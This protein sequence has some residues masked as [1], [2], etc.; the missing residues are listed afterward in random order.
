MNRSFAAAVVTV[1]LAAIYM[2]IQVGMVRPH[3]WPG[4]HG[5]Q[6]AAE[7]RSARMGRPPVLEMEALRIR[8]VLPLSPA[9]RAGIREGDIVLE[10]LDRTTGTRLDARNFDE[11]GLDQRMLVWRAAYR[12]GVRDPVTVTVR[13][14]PDP[15]ELPIDL[16]R[17]A[18]WELGADTFMAWTKLHISDLLQIV[19]FICLSAI[20]LALRASDPTA[21]L[22][23]A[24]L[25]FCAV[26][27]GG[28]PL[29]EEY[30]LPQ[31]LAFVTTLFA[32]TATPLAFVAT[33]F[34]I[35]YFPRKSATLIRRPW[36]KAVPFI[37]TA[38]MFVL[39]AASALFVSGVDAALPIVSW[40]VSHPW[41]YFGSFAAGIALNIAVMVEAVHRWRTN[42]D[43]TERRRVAIS[44]VTI[45]PGVLAYAIKEGVPGVGYLLGRDWALPWWLMLG[46]Q[47]L[48]LLPAFGL[49]YAVAVNRV[50][51]PV[52]VLRRSVQYAL[53]RKTL[54]LIALLPAAA[55]V[56]SFVRNRDMTIGMLVSGRP[57]FYLLTTAALIAAIKYRDAERLWLDRHFFREAYDAR[58]ILLS[59]ASRVTYE[60]DP[61]ELTALVADRIDTA[62][63]PEMIAMLVAGVDEGQLRCV[64][65]LRGTA[66]PLPI[67]SGLVTMLQWSN[68]PLELYVDDERS[69]SKRLPKADQEWLRSTGAVLLVPVIARRTGADTAASKTELIAMI[70]L[71]MR[72]SEEPYTAE[73]RQLLASIAGQVG[74]ALDVVRLRQRVAITPVPAAASNDALTT[75]TPADSIM[76]CPQCGRC[77][78]T[79][80]TTCPEDGVAMRLVPR[81][82]HVIE[83]K[84]R[85]DQ[86]IG[87]G[88]MG[89]VYRARDVR[90]DRDVAIKVVRADLLNDAES[91]SRFRREAQIVAR[92]QHPGIVAVFDYGTFP[93]GSAFLV[94]ELLRGE[95]LRRVLRREGSL[96][97]ARALPL[98][99]AICTAVHAAHREGVLHR[100]LKPENILLVDGADEPQSGQGSTTDVAVKVLDFGVAKLVSDRSP[101]QTAMATVTTAG[102]VVGTPAYMAPEQLRSETVD[103]RTDVFSLGVLTYEM[104]T[105]DLPFG[106]A[107]LWDIGLQQTRGMKPMQVPRDGVAPHVEQ[108]VSR[109]LNLD[110]ARRPA[111]AAEFAALLTSS[112]S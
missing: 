90:L 62:L 75:T 112:V 107:S 56:S 91:R 11:I 16:E 50:F 58:E 78:A 25:T 28:P 21:V 31:P 71:G 38:P 66:P 43:V 12:A 108:A 60:T 93:D 41:L 27:A 94:M 51:G 52:T 8:S 100:D 85:L 39:T 17:P 30:L 103:A 45:V 15:R 82:P 5:A 95:D 99:S 18:A 57:L 74:L 37:V 73:D 109:A 64:S 87:R 24:A 70:A 35:G 69:P 55:L 20:L 53:A 54:T 110:P 76:E 106:R 34:A 72:R 36:L 23:V 1:A 102:M 2:V 67:D 59:L 98:M 19:V 7:V 4:G 92:L 22:A 29:G 42:Q 44:V 101:D 97:A 48:I 10:Q 47:I 111:S 13:H 79:G 105:G 84:Y 83:R 3:L 26:A 88:G 14:P 89:A 49:T 40:D 77:A 46:L 33:S 68:E 104:L 32:W 86:V 9:D 61:N 81:V 63:H 65:S 6:L 96:P 80:V